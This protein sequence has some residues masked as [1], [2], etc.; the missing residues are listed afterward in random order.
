[1]LY[2]NT[3]RQA[4]SF[5]RF[6]EKSIKEKG[7]G[8]EAGAMEWLTEVKRDIRREVKVKCGGIFEEIE[9]YFVGGWDNDYMD[10]CYLKYFFPDQHWTDEEKAKFKEDFWIECPNSPYDC[11]GATFTS[12]IS[13]FDVPKGTLVYMRISIDV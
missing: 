13:I 6:I 11:T 5:A 4:Y 9:E 8:N 7:F 3:L 1:M 12:W 2:G 10:G